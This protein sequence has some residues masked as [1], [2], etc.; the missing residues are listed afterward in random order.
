ML[1]LA[2][3]LSIFLQIENLITSYT[4]ARQ[5][6]CIVVISVSSRRSLKQSIWSP[7][8][9]L[10]LL[11]FLVKESNYSTYEDEQSEYKIKIFDGSSPQPPH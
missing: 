7:S 2:F 4:F 10:M 5:V 11:A 6:T 1:F 9:N 3:D 8:K